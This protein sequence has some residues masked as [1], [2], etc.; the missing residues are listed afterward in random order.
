MTAIGR[1]AAVEATDGV[2]E[3]A[4][5]AMNR[6]RVLGRGYFGDRRADGSGT[7][8]GGTAAKMDRI[9]DRATDGG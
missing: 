9:K 3:G 6:V 8:T 5:R 4:V 1:A 2:T 7:E